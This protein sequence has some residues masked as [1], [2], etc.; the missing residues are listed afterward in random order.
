MLN[1]HY[2]FV[3]SNVRNNLAV[4]MIWLSLQFLVL[5]PLSLLEYHSLWG[6]EFH[7][8]D[9]QNMQKLDEASIKK[10]VHY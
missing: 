9:L 3:H 1:Y 5:R 6:L 10:A 8:P 2:Y 4:R 7:V